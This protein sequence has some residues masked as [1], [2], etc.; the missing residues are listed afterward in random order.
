MDLNKKLQEER[1]SKPYSHPLSREHLG[2]KVD[3]RKKTIMKYIL[4]YVQGA[5]F[6]SVVPYKAL[7]ISKY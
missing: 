1:T 2:L 3:E 6:I 5:A 7:L 4:E